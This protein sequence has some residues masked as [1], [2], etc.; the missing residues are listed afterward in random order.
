[1]IFKKE[2]EMAQ[3]WKYV[4]LRGFT[5]SELLF[6]EKETRDILRFFFPSDR[7]QIDATKVTDELRGFSQ[8]LLVAAVD[9]TYAM[10]WVDVT[11]RSVANPGAGV[12]SA[13]QKLARNATRYWFKNLKGGQ[14]L[15]NIKI[16][17]SV[18]AKLSVSF[19]SPFQIILL[20][21]SK[22]M[23][24]HSLVACI[25]CALPQQGQRVWG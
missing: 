5:G 24:T 9:A 13:L 1:L 25:N 17:E 3:E 6:D 7:S 20:A 19:R 11:F 16:Y 12:K 14:S 18:R 15:S 22:G 8:G 21:K 23:N 2:S 4:Q 10:G